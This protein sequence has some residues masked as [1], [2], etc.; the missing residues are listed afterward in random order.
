MVFLTKPDCLKAYESVSDPTKERV[1]SR[2]P[3]S[4]EP[5]CGDSVADRGVTGDATAG[6][7][8]D[9]S[10]PSRL[11]SESSESGCLP[12]GFARFFSPG[13]KGLSSSR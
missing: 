1:A 11:T 8:A 6:E 7:A 5:V 9:G 3:A 10:D 2:S 4:S 12:L 13:A